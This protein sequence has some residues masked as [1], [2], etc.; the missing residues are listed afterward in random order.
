MFVLRHAMFI[1]LI[2]FITCSDAIFVFGVPQRSKTP[3]DLNLPKDGAG[4]L[5]FS[6]QHISLDNICE[7]GKTTKNQTNGK[8]VGSLSADSA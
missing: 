4:I 1:F 3:I 6:I 5:N 8:Y 2:M 7:N